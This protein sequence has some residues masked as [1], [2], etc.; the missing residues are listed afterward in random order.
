MR[1]APALVLATLLLA[2]GCAG[3]RRAPPTLA[4][5]P[6]AVSLLGTPLYAPELPLEQ[7]QRLEAQLAEAY[8]AYAR[9][10]EDADAILWLGRRVAYLGRYRDAL[11]I[12]SEGIR[13]H[14]DDARM[15]RHRGH[16]QITVRRFDLAVRDLEHAARLIQ[17]RPDEVEPDGMPNA[18]GI[19]LTTLHFN[20]W[21]HLGVAYYLRGEFGRAA[22]AFRNAVVVA[23]HDDSR[24]AATDWAYMALRRQ[25]R[26]VEA[27]ELLATIPPG[28]EMIEN[29]AYYR[30]LMMYQGRVSPDS[31][32]SGDGNDAVTMA[33]Q[34]Y[35]VGN[36]H[37]VNGRREQAEEIF[38]R[39]V[40]AENWAVFGY[41]AAEAD[42]RRIR[43]R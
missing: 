14:P 26:T 29:A 5:V 23:T 35:A 19:P 4:G 34:G 37:L 39:V 38:W 10:P 21:Y 33:T 40:S 25:G 7:R 42:L 20:V 16:R 3:I 32:L 9:D 15:Y 17:A 24:V 27:A 11:A 36:W 12:Y 41:I 18:R 2:A 8:A 30:R 31:L 43:R 22:L 6:E 28:L 13:R 1:I